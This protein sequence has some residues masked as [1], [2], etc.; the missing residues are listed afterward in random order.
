MSEVQV[1]I[2]QFRDSIRDLARPN[3]F[4]VELFFPE[5]GTIKSGADSGINST[6]A[7]NSSKSTV[8]GDTPGAVSYTHLT[9]PTIVDV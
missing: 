7:E 6:V 9:L 8:G 4:Q 3:L 5:G 2:L 1:P